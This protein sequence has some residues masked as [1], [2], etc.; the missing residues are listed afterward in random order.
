MDQGFGLCEVDP[1]VAAGLDDGVGVVEQ[2]V[3]EVALAQVEPDALDRVE[4]GTVGRQ[5]RQGDVVRHLERP[6]VVPSGAVEGDDGVGVPGQDLGELPEEDV[7]GPGRD[8]GQD[9][10]EVLARG[11]AHGGEDVGPV[12]A[13]VAAPRRARALGPPAVADPAL[14]ADAGFVLEPELQ[15]LVRMRRG[16]GRQCV[17]QPLFLNAA[18]A[19]GSPLGCDGRAFCQD[20]PRR[21][22]TFHRLPG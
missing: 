9:E 15:A 7:H 20:R 4:L 6:L 8:L 10:G 5:R 13:L 21:R 14:V 2:A 17:A 22:S 19:P 1:S 11:R 18:R 16:G 3:G 12:V